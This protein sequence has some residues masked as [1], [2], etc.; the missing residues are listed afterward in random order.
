MI[1]RLTGTLIEVFEDSV[2][3]ERDGVA[4]EVLVPRFAVAELAS[5]RGRQVTLKTN[6]FLEG[7]HTSG[8]LVPRILREEKGTQLVLTGG[9]GWIMLPFMPR[10]ARV[11]PGRQTP[12]AHFAHHPLARP[13]RVDR[14]RATSAWYPQ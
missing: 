2:V 9:F 12:L 6:E 1:V 7:S 3:L 4:R 13:E 8:H 5:N 14:P 11:A 10:Q